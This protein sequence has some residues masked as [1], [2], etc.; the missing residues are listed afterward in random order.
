MLMLMLMLCC[1]VLC[2]LPP[3]S[4]ALNLNFTH[5]QLRETRKPKWIPNTC[6]QICELVMAHMGNDWPC[7]TELGRWQRQIQSIKWHRR[8]EV[9]EN[10]TV[11]SQTK[12]KTKPS[13]PSK[14]HFFIQMQ[15]AGHTFASHVAGCLEVPAPCS[16][17]RKKWQKTKWMLLGALRSLQQT[18]EKK[19]EQRSG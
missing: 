11:Y 7:L 5:A 17:N 10:E 4:E 3:I 9:S 2:Y 1:A 15:V 19:N 12:G 13:K 16:C 14:L 18:D 8:I 6:K